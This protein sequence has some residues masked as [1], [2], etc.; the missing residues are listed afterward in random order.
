MT[1]GCWK[2]PDDYEFYKNV[3]LDNKK[4]CLLY[5]RRTEVKLL[6]DLEP[7]FDHCETLYTKCDFKLETCTQQQILRLEKEF[8]RHDALVNRELKYQLELVEK[9]WDFSQR[10]LILTC[11]GV[12]FKLYPEW[13]S[14][15]L[16]RKALHDF[17][18][19]LKRIKKSN[20]RMTK[21]LGY[22]KKCMKE[23]YLRITKL[24]K[25]VDSVFL[26][27]NHRQRPLVDIVDM[28]EELYNYFYC[29]ATKLNNWMLLMDPGDSRSIDDYKAL[30][31]A[32][33]DFKKYTLMGMEHCK[34]FR[35]ERGLKFGPNE[36]CKLLVNRK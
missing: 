19:N 2:L 30:V 31:E 36:T 21:S 3:K 29:V 12:C 25:T 35:I 23:L 20:A 34:C 16:E 1:C 5:P 6:K 27:G 17:H 9:M 10:Y 4:F 7:N 33:E 22:I 11:G 28:L 8:R 32:R 13:I 15:Q 18:F 26:K 24:D 14:K